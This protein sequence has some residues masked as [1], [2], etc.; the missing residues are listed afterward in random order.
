M[1]DKKS[2]VHPTSAPTTCRHYTWSLVEKSWAGSKSATC[3]LCHQRRKDCDDGVMM[4][5]LPPITER[6]ARKLALE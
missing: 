6:F 2:V 4:L 1:V 5:E 3:S